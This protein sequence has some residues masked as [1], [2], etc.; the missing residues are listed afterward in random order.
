MSKKYQ[1]K[2]SCQVKSPVKLHNQ[3]KLEVP[4]EEK[5][6]K[7]Q[8]PGWASWT[9]PY[10]KVYH[11]NQVRQ[12]DWKGMVPWEAPQAKGESSKS[13]KLIQHQKCPNESELKWKY[14]TL[15]K[16][17]IISQAW[18]DNQK[19]KLVKDNNLAM[20]HLGEMIQK[21]QVS[22]GKEYQERTMLKNETVMACRKLGS[23]WHLMQHHGQSMHSLSQIL[24]RG[25]REDIYNPIDV[26]L[27][28]G[29]NQEMLNYIGKPSMQ[30]RKLFSQAPLK[31]ISKAQIAQG[32]L[33]SWTS[34]EPRICN[35]G[36]KHF[37][38]KH[39]GSTMAISDNQSDGQDAKADR[40][41]DWLGQTN[42][43]E[44][45]TLEGSRAW[46]PEVLRE[47]CIKSQDQEQSDIAGQEGDILKEVWIKEEQ[48]KFF[49]G[50]ESCEI[51]D[52]STNGTANEKFDE[53]ALD[54]VAKMVQQDKED[55]QVGKAKEEGLD[56]LR[57][58]LCVDRKMLV[59]L[60]IE[61]EKERNA[62]AIATSKTMAMI[63]R[64]QEGKLAMQLVVAQLQRMAEEK[65]EYDEHAM[66]LL[67]EF[68]FK[69]EAEKHALEKNLIMDT[70]GALVLAQSLPQMTYY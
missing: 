52:K 58:A 14:K 42:I 49:V 54:V 50:F 37:S 15:W 32:R 62:V 19:G 39:G 46:E 43:S 24:G 64:L 66:V 41:L 45:E 27:S 34:C 36:T 10:T 44:S 55:I 1:S 69:R 48:L 5:V 59:A 68:L 25:I 18:L 13:N 56:V 61:L 17:Q 35:H 23:C 2:A 51:Q 4:K 26:Q 47:G 63:S 20:P 29:K 16:E 7:R 3:K 38:F 6:A 40:Q 28:E 70:L 22:S 9:E 67:K 11:D 30:A 53:S 12:R 60:E 31:I 8:C 21:T 65:A 33:G 57:E